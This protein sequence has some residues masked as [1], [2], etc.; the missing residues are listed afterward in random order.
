MRFNVLLALLVA[1]GCAQSSTIT[2]N[3]CEV[4]AYRS[5]GGGASFTSGINHPKGQYRNFAE[6]ALVEDHWLIKQRN[7]GEATA[8]QQFCRVQ[9]M[10]SKSRAEAARLDEAA[11]GKR[12][13]CGEEYASILDRVRSSWQP[14]ELQTATAQTCGA[15]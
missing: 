2:A 14:Q 5:I 12:G 3:N 15:I 10:L 1:T 11:Q 13:M 8:D 6:L 4:V 9:L 7:W